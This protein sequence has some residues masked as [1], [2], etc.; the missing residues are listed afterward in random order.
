MIGV[1][2]WYV[3]VVTGFAGL[4]QYRDSNTRHTLVG[5]VVVL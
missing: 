4:V 1:Q 2:V 5:L 3:S